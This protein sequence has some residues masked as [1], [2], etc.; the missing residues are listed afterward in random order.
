MKSCDANSRKNIFA[1]SGGK[2]FMERLHFFRSS[3]WPED[4]LDGNAVPQDVTPGRAAFNSL[5]RPLDLTSL[6]QTLIGNSTSPVS[7]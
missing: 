4:R 6:P 1:E 3:H 7:T 2:H 5:G